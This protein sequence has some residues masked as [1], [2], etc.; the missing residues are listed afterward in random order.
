MTDTEGADS[1][2]TSDDTEAKQRSYKVLCTLLLLDS[3]SMEQKLD[4][5]DKLPNS[6]LINIIMNDK[7]DDSVR[8]KIND[9]LSEE[10]KD[11]DIEEG[12]TKWFD[13]EDASYRQKC[14]AAFSILEKTMKSDKIIESDVAEYKKGANQK[15][16]YFPMSNTV[17]KHF[18]RFWNSFRGA[19]PEAKVS[20]GINSLTPFQLAAKESKQFLFKKAPP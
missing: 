19:E 11:I 2:G 5:V 8:V 17:E 13:P 16:V 12:Q 20:E 9:R 4:I 3:V 14:D 6:W 1:R 18:I 7:L 10:I 15:K